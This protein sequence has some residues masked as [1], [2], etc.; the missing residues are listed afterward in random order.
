[1]DV[2]H[3]IPGSAGIPS[4]GERPGAR[5]WRTLALLS[6]A[7]L[8]GMS[9]WFTASATSPQLRALWDL[10]AGEAGWLTTIVQLG[11]VAGTATA[12]VLNFA[13]I[14]PSRRYFA[15]A[16]M[17]AAGANAALVIAPGYGAALACRFLT[18]LFLAGVY[19][20]AMKMI[21]TWFRSARGFAIGTIVGALTVGKALPYLV[22]AIGTAGHE[23]VVLSA[24]GGALLSALLVAALYRDGPYP[25]ARRP[26]SWGLVRTVVAHRETRLAVGG[27]LGHMW[28][29]YACWATLSAF[30]IAHFTAGGFEIGKS[31]SFAGVSS[32]AFIA[33]GGLGSVVAGAWAD[34]WGRENVAAG[35]MAISG[36]CALSI[37]WLVSGPTWAVIT[38]GVIWGCAVVADSAQFSALVTEVSPAH[39]VGTALTL[40]T[41]LGFLLTAGSIWL[42]VELAGL[43]GWGVAFMVLAAGPALGIWAILRLKIERLSTLR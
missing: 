15:G 14:I 22:G 35:A 27:Y 21:A 23:L 5:A 7:E 12:A 37:G 39:S 30:M 24:S 32:F 13:D 3:T 10:S 34:R 33:A 29:L 20:P 6:A 26:F 11:F 36:L 17:L 25:F 40:Q 19:P 18:G 38:I 41:S 9:L 2:T 8:L 31:V 43:L 1:V 16:A 4:A 42:T 28:E